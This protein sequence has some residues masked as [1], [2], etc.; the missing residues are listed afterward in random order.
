MMYGILLALDNTP[1][2]SLAGILEKEDGS[3]GGTFRKEVIKLG[4]YVKGNKGKPFEITAAVLNNWVAQFR[5]MRKNGDKV[6]VPLGHKVTAET[7][8]GWVKELFVDGDVLVMTAELFDKDVANLVKRNDV[9]L[10]SPPEWI[11]GKGNRYVQP[12]L[13]IA[14]TPTPVVPGLDEFRPLAASFGDDDMGIDLKKLGADLGIKDELTEGTAATLILSHCASMKDASDKATKKVGEL[15]KKVEA[16]AKATDDE[17]DDDKPI[18]SPLLL[19]MGVKNRKMVLAASVAAAHITP[20]VRND[21]EE[22]FIGEEGEAIRLS[23]ETET[24]DVFDRVMEAIAKNDPV[25]LGEQTGRQ[26]NLTLSDPLKDED[27]NCLVLDAERRA[28]EEVAAV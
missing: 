9:S 21:F 6:P 16:L 27:A 2:L 1:F 11:S 12:I 28:K 19:S 8:R 26:D 10:F 23:F 7:N 4:R 22:I 15:G 5:E 20:D 25:K 24:D 14:L 13:H 17:K 18:I 3:T